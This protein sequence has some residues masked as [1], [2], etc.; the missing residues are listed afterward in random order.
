MIKLYA[1]SLGTR[2]KVRFLSLGIKYFTLLSSH[3]LLAVDLL[4]LKSALL[5]FL[6]HFIADQAQVNEISTKLNK[7][8]V[9]FRSLSLC[10]ENSV[11][12]RS[13]FD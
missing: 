7:M 9:C 11:S 4:V 3:S 13:L 10:M 5:N 12:D 8:N 6:F 2:Q 1:S